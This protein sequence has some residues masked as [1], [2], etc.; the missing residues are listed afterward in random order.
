MPK[1]AVVITV[2]DGNDSH[3]SCLE[4][5]QKQID[6]VASEGRYSFSIFLND[7]GVEGYPA[8]WKKASEEGADL[9][10]WMDNDLMLA[11]GSLASFLENSEFLRHKSVIT[12]TVSRPDKT[13]LFGG[14]TRRG[15]LIDPDPTIPVP[16][17]LFDMALALVPAA[18][19]SSLENP[20]D[21]FRRRLM[22][23]GFGAKVAKAGV[24]RVIAPGIQARTARKIDIPAW[25]DPDST[26]KDKL[27]W[28]MQ[29]FIKKMNTNSKNN[30]K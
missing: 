1:V 14:R 4:E 13:L 26:L 23:Y 22:D 11:E 2:L 10:L 15:R 18:A 20:A 29:D 27:A 25:K 16:C 9:F 21:F 19:F 12:G 24:P 3:E 28:V 30:T 7:Q 8:V 17:H 5:C 6:G